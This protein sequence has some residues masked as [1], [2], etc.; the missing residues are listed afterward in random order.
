[1]RGHLE[2]PGAA[3]QPRVRPRQA[4]CPGWVYKEA[5]TEPTI[6]YLPLA[7][8]PSQI[9]IVTKDMQLV[10]QTGDSVVSLTEGLAS[11]VGCVTRLVLAA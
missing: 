9:N 6:T 5:T 1:M 11:L 3:G 8:P 4:R 7:V 2:Q 10:G